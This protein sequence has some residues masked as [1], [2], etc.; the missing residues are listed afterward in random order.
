M[1]GLDVQVCLD[2]FH[3]CLWF[4]CDYSS[5]P[6]TLKCHHSSDDK[7]YGHVNLTDRLN[8]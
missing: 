3:I 7:L 1:R 5:V 6:F 2:I 4:W 8:I